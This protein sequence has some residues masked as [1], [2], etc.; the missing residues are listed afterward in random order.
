MEDKGV[1]GTCTSSQ[2]NFFRKKICL[3]IGYSPP[4]W[5][6]L[7]P[8]LILNSLCLASK[9]LWLPTLCSLNIGNRIG[10]HADSKKSTGVTPSFKIQGIIIII[11]TFIPIRLVYNRTRLVSFFTTIIGKGRS[12]KTVRFVCLGSGMP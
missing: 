7:D 1:R 9:S 5:E 8:P 10:C 11:I 2:S 12:L 3:I 6:I 4:L